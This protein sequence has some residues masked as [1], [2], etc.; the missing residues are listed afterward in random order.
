MIRYRS[1]RRYVIP[2][3]VSG[4]IILLWLVFDSHRKLG[5]LTNLN[6]NVIMTEMAIQQKITTISTD[7]SQIPSTNCEC[8]KCKKCNSMFNLIKLPRFWLALIHNDVVSE[9]I[10]EKRVWEKETTNY[11]ETF[12]LPGQTI[13]ELGA[14]I[15]YYTNLMAAL[16]GPTGKIYSYECNSDQNE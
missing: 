5:M 16:V 12:M 2:I 14:N 10:L 7:I 9:M 1:N 8:P 13:V 11:L 3:L 4:W 15:G 6:Q